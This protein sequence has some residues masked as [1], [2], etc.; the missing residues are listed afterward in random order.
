MTGRSA[1]EDAQFYAAVIA[2]K[3]THGISVSPY[4][5][6]IAYLI[7]TS[8]TDHSVELNKGTKTAIAR[9]EGENIQ[10]KPQQQGLQDR[11]NDRNVRVF[12][13]RKAIV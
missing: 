1:K 8:V 13:R 3:S 7:L 6:V 5:K 4:Q 2:V 12:R 10:R 9:G 11:K